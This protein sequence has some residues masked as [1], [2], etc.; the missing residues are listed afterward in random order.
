MKKC[1][2]CAEMVQEEAIKC[3]H[4]GSKLEKQPLYFLWFFAALLI[5][6]GVGVFLYLAEPDPPISKPS[7]PISIID[8]L[9]S[10][11]EV[12]SVSWKGSDLFVDFYPKAG[13]AVKTM[14]TAAKHITK[15]SGGSL[16]VY[17]TKGGSEDDNIF[18]VV[19]AY[20]GEIMESREF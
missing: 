1:P 6:A 19:R 17:G 3:K 10:V 11:P 9:N 14:R 2:Y 8:A 7:E 13:Y 5:L 4:C 12:K 18:W 15:E 20:D 16:L